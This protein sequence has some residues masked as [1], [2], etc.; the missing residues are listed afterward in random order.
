MGL[1]D[2]WLRTSGWLSAHR[3][4]GHPE[5]HPQVDA[6][7]LISEGTEPSVNEQAAQNSQVVVK[8]VQPADKYEA[9]EKLQAGFDKLIGQLQSINEHLDRQLTQHEEMVSRMDKLPKLLES[10]P[11]VAENQK[12]LTE[13]M[14]EHLQAIITKDQQFIDAVE[15]IPIETAKQ[16]D[17]LADINH[18]LAAA[19]DADVQMAESFNKF[20]QTLDKL[21]QSTTGQTDSILQM[22]RT[23]A[24]SDRYLKYLISKQNR[25]VI[26]VFMI[27][28]SVCAVVILILT[29]IIIYLRQ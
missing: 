20:N 17:S 26:W 13:G 29:G 18:Q 6:E 3:V 4:G 9:I 1:K 12:K 16:T 11:V 8:A 7:G 28:I 10:F 25:R 21:E 5:Y 15:K 23:F 27:A 2:L 22:N 24:A 14:L 19:A